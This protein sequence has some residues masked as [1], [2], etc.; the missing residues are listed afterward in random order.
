MIS[1]AAK[2]YDENT[3]NN[4]MHITVFNDIDNKEFHVESIWTVLANARSLFYHTL[5]FV[6]VFARPGTSLVRTL[7][8]SFQL[9]TDS[10]HRQN[11][12]LWYVIHQVYLILIITP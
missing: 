4:L 2:L 8:S 10:C 1:L 3:L 12:A 11:S 9:D 7:G 5:M 6:V